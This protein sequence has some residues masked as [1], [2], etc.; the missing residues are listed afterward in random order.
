LLRTIRTSADGHVARVAIWALGRYRY[1]SAVAGLIECFEV[2]FVKKV[3]MKTNA[4]AFEDEIGAALE[5]ITGKRFGAD[6][7]A[8]R[9]WWAAEGR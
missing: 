2:D 7:A 6:A 5:K 3:M 1:P 9:A 8:W 4:E